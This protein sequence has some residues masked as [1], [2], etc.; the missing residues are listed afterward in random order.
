MWA[1]DVRNQYYRIHFVGLVIITRII[2][3]TY[4]SLH[5]QRNKKMSV[6]LGIRYLCGDRSGAVVNSSGNAETWPARMMAAHGGFGTMVDYPAGYDMHLCQWNC[7]RLQKYNEFYHF[8]HCFWIRR[9]EPKRRT[10]YFWPSWP[11]FTFESSLRSSRQSIGICTGAYGYTS[12]WSYLEGLSTCSRPTSALA[13]QPLR[14]PEDDIIQGYVMDSD[15]YILG[16][17]HY[18]MMVEHV[19]FYKSN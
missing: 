7:K 1:G 19:S 16:K 3:N 15:G 8:T 14:D 4:R 17:F 2:R 18:Q 10:P 6:S 11:A 9:V 12:V 13:S 5:Q